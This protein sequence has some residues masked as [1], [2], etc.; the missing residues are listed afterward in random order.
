[1]NQATRMLGRS[2]LLAAFAAGLAGCG[3]GSGYRSSA[4][5]PSGYVYY[6]DNVYS[7]PTRNGFYYGPRNEQDRPA[8]ST[9]FDISNIW[10]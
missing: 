3:S 6:P 8:S 7:G 5:Y 1:M 9:D 4:Y 10:R 2:L